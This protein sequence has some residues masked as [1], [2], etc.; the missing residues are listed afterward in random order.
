VTVL[1]KYAQFGGRANLPEFW[2]FFLFVSVVNFAARAIDIWVLEIPATGFG[3]SSL[4]T[5][6]VFLPTL[7]VTVRRLR[8]GGNNW[9]QLLWLFVPVAGL[10]IVILRLCDPAREPDLDPVMAPGQ[11]PAPPSGTTT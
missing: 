10:V 7:A 9:V 6:A 3:I 5:I 1:R 11:N 2:L 4:W 8:D